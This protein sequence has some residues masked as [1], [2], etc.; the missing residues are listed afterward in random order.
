MA[1]AVPP[2]PAGILPT[3]YGA[4]AH[5]GRGDADALIALVQRQHQG[6]A[7]GDL[8]GL[9]RDLEAQGAALARSG[10]P[11]ERGLLALA[12]DMDLTLAQ[13]GGGS[14]DAGAMAIAAA[15][16]AVAGQLALHAGYVR[17][18]AEARPAATAPDD[19]RRA[20]DLHEEVGNLGVVKRQLQDMAADLEQGRTRQACRRLE[21]TAAMVT[22]A[23]QTVRG[24]LRDRRDEDRARHRRVEPAPIGAPALTARERE[25]LRLLADGL[26]V[27][28]V[29]ARLDRS[30]KTAAVHTYNV[31]HK[32]G[33]HNRAALVRY[34][35]AHQLVPV[36]V[37]EETA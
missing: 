6:L 12:L 27:K 32:L 11:E 9:R 23:I 7:D 29:A 26:S 2:H 4:V 15:R 30:V 21:E 24:G 33:V 34:A 8:D 1:A 13:I 3:W 14:P 18:R 37:V 28:E 36:P 19:R 20:H 16:I 25:V 17:A 31:M 5:L 10:V 35:I 22:D